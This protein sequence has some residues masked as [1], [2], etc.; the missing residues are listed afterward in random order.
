MSGKFGSADLLANQDN[1][2][3]QAPASLITTVTG[4]VVNRGTS[5]TGIKVAIGSGVAPAVQD[6]IY[7]GKMIEPNETFTFG[8]I[9]MSAGENLWINP[10]DANLSARVQGFG[11]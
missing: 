5:P 1:L 9:V 8:P 3:C 6:Y 7:F 11:D 10:N 4:F 2:L